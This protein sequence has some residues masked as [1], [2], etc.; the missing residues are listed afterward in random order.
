MFLQGDNGVL[1]SAEARK[2][3]EGNE[4][5]MKKFLAVLLVLVIGV[6]WIFSV[7]GVGS[8]DALQDRLKLGLDFK[9]GVYVVM[10][11]QTDAEGPELKELMQQTQAIIEQRVNQMGLSEPVVTIEGENRIRV[12]LPGAED[13]N[14]A[15]ET[16]G[17]T[18]QLYF[19]LGDG[20]VVLDGSHVK[21]ASVGKD[22]MGFPAVDLEFDSEG[23]TLFEQGTGKAAAGVMN[24]TTGQLDH[25]IYIVLDNQVISYPQASQAIS[26]GRAQIT[27]KFTA[28]E[29]TNLSV[30]I[31]G[32]SLPVGLEE[33]ET[34]V[35][36]PSLGIDSLKNSVIA[37][38]I[39][40]GLIMLFMLFAYW[41]MGL[42]ADVALA[43]YILLTF[44]IL[45]AL[46][47]VLNLPGIAGIILSIGMAVDA[48]VIIFARIREEYRKGKSTR[49]AVDS[50]FKR[51]LATIIDSQ[52]TTMIAG[53]ILYQLGTGPVRGFAMTLMIGIVI[54]I[55]TAVLVTQFLL[56]TMVGSKL[57]GGE[58]IYGLS[59]GIYFKREFSFIKHRK[60][61]YIVSIAF[62]VLGLAVGMIRGFNYGIDFTGGTMLE[63]D[64]GRQ[65][66]V[67][68]VEKVM[69]SHD[70]DCTVVHA[71][72]GNEEVI[73]KT[74][75]ALDNV[76]RQELLKDFYTA[77]DIT[78][79][80]VLSIEQ[81][82]A[83]VGDMLK[84]NAIKAVIIAALCMLVYIIIRFE[85]KFGLAAIVDLIHD[86]LIVV[87]FYGLFHIPINN[88][89]IAGVLIV[90]GYS[91]NDTIV[92]FDRIRENLSVMKR[93]RMEELID[94]SINQTLVRSCTTSLTT[95]ICIIPLYILGG[96]TIQE[97]I[98]PLV[99]G[100]LGGTISSITIASQTYYLIDRA[101]GKPRYKGANSGN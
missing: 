55:L 34:S 44:W 39:G 87:A 17:K 73:I 41:A 38:V 21:D 96:S 36:G 12:E 25:C 29:V 49:A 64:M 76:A 97:F 32:G 14:Q 78:E 60:V 22:E 85:W 11:A 8:F 57:L 28:D 66:S 84:G 40:I 101:S 18:A 24:E 1:I 4:N 5:T 91:I 2:T 58:K 45:A 72:E 43:L 70:Y 30:L 19:L 59:K 88:P 68:E 63:I 37:G 81:F 33:V 61:F 90:V 54:S 10:E 69:K 50:G 20:S 27:G 48:N 67:E 56:K 65:V 92:V 93:S 79:E 31:R 77:F 62:I 26:G 83:S 15:I 75:A 98:L 46:S 100:V 99:V 51:A 52:L 53:I 47:A 16:I 9:G 23:A 6:A 42:V 95:I 3:K 80:N 86:V 94:K 89:F 71:G 35:I 7:A 82:S 74:T 13:S